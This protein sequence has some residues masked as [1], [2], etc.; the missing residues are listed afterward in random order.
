V[1]SIIQR[2]RSP[3]A[4]A[5]T[6]YRSPRLRRFVARGAVGGLL[7]TLLMTLY[8]LP[9]FRALP[10]TA[11][12]WATYVGGGDATDYP[13]EGLL[14]HAL[15]GGAAGAAFGP[16]FESV[17]SAVPLPREHAGVLL[18]VGY[19][20]ALSAFGERVL[21]E[22]LLGEDLEPQESLIF[23]A[24]HLVYGLTLGTW[25]SSRE[26]LGDVYDE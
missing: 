18:G 4:R 12:F 2:L 6:S 20:L 26:E 13:L 14:L 3:G 15:Y 11:D 5:A 19:G 21:I 10:P 22:G 17:R 23:H 24:G 1:G 25:V 7:G 8:R 16:L 9:V